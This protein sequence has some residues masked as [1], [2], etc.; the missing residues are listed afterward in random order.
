MSCVR[1]AH[2]EFSEYY[3]LTLGTGNHSQLR[4]T[5]YGPVCVSPIKSAP[6]SLSTKTISR[7]SASVDS[8]LCV[9]PPALV[10]RARS[11]CPMHAE[12]NY[13]IP[14]PSGVLRSQVLALPWLEKKIKVTRSWRVLLPH[15]R[16]TI[17]E[18]EHEGMTENRSDRAAP[19]DIIHVC[20]RT[21]RSSPCD[22]LAYA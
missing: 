14:V 1:W 8:A 20:M 10:V 17:S 7:R 15:S 19:D 2:L 22:P 16:R 9:R 11:L 5:D 13:T 3:H 18:Q 6:R 12:N 21:S 4:P